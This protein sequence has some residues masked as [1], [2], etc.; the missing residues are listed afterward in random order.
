MLYG[1]SK[2]AVRQPLCPWNYRIWKVCSL[3]HPLI[4][5]LNSPS[6]WSRFTSSNLASCIR[7]SWCS[8]LCI[9]ENKCWLHCRAPTFILHSW[10]G[11]P[12]CLLLLHF[13][14][15]SYQHLL[16][17]CISLSGNDVASGPYLILQFQA[18]CFLPQ[19]CLF[20]LQ[21]IHLLID[22]ILLSP[23]AQADMFG[24]FHSPAICTISVPFPFWFDFCIMI[25][26]C[27]HFIA[28]VNFLS[29]YPPFNQATW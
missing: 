21:I 2:N 17:E 20:P 12:C 3:P 1:G 24:M 7:Y 25:T 9:G 19:N 28:F 18:T 23:L 4:R 5:D 6:K 27:P 11:D 13:S 8:L 10:L 15:H 14:S 26:N 29:N 16:K 22:S